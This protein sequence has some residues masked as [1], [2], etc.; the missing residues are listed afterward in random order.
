MYT[1]KRE[2][3]KEY[4]SDIAVVGGGVAGCAAAI[5]AARLGA[6]TLLIE[7]SGVLGGQA[8]LGLVTPLS[9]DRSRSGI[10]F[11]GLINEIS[12]EVIRLSS[13]YCIPKSNDTDSALTAAGS[14]IAAPHI[15]KYVLMKLCRDS[16]VKIL[17]HTSLIGADTGD[18]RVERL[19]VSEKSGLAVVESKMFI[20]ADGDG[21]L[22]SFAKDDY[23]LG[24]EPEAWASLAENGLDTVHFTD[25]SQ[26]KYTPKNNHAVQP[27][28]IFFTMGGVDYPRAAAFNNKD[29]RYADLGLSF[30]EFATLPYAGNCGF[31][32]IKEDKRLPL[33]QGRI[34]VSRGVRNDVAV[35][36]MS[37]VIGIDGSDADSLNRGELLAQQQV[38]D[39]VDF[40]KR[41]VPG[42]ERAYYLE[43]AG[44]LG[45]RES[46]RLAGRYVL[47]GGDVINCRRFDDAVA[48][49]SY[50]IDI[51]D[52]NGKSKAIGGEIHGDFYEIPLRSLESAKYDNLFAAGRCISADHVAHSSTRIQ[53]TCILTGQAAGTAAALSLYGSKASPEAVRSQLIASGV[54][55][56]DK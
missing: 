2:I 9:S 17:F 20:D 38:I 37:R 31:E 14:R 32:Q 8:G 30:E 53:G 11:G 7:Q 46:R 40:L 23:M 49:G 26:S 13:E 48:R 29:L 3:T 21:E 1:F 6:N 43:S 16:G 25:K 47:T 51:H 35:V 22:M 33:P 52:P 34:L 45:V 41:F 28:S 15:L 4:K 27:V 42:F 39:L 50:I 44:T 56:G 12:A 18:N 36:N 19:I 5:A 24:S 10:P 55:L 54:W